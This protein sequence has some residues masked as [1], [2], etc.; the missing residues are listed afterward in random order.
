MI[1]EDLVEHFTRENNNIQKGE[2]NSNKVEDR[3][4]NLIK[5]SL[6]GFGIIVI[7]FAYLIYGGYFK[8][9]CPSIPACPEIPE[10]NLQCPEQIECPSFPNITIPD[11]NN[12]CNFPNKLEL[13]VN[14]ES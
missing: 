6:V 9:E 10:C 2:N 7:I 8:T 5:G 13:E 14:N 4:F 11:C 3:Y 1:S 12:V